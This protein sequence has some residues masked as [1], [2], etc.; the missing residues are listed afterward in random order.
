MQFEQF[1]RKPFV[2][3]AIQITE[4]NI[5]ELAKFIGT[6]ERKDDG[7]PY[8]Q[9]D[10]TKVPNLFRVYPGF[11]MTRMGKNTRCYA[12]NIFAKEFKPSTPEL[13]SHVKAI[14]G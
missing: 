11:W 8:I 7:R 4:E 12:E 2:V 5:E 6:L 14:G 10:K 1:V 3:Q 13:E 9:V